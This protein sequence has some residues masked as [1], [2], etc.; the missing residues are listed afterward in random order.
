M[1]RQK[2][3]SGNRFAEQSA[4]FGDPVPELPSFA[5][6]PEETKRAVERNAIQRGV[7]L[8]KIL[9]SLNMDEAIATIRKIA[10]EYDKEEIR[11]AA[12]AL[13][14]DVV[15][16]T[17]LDQ[18]DPPIP[19]PW[20]FCTPTYLVENPRLVMYYRNVAMLSRKVMNGIGLGT[21][22][23]ELNLV[24]PPAS[25]AAE[26]AHYFNKIIGEL[27]KTGGVTPQR[28][29]EMAFANLGDSLGGV[30]RNEVGRLAST[31]V[32]R[33]L[34]IHLHQKWHLASLTYRLKGRVMP[35]D[36]EDEDRVDS[37]ADQVLTVSP[38]MDLESALA[39]L[40]SQR[41]KYREV[42]LRNGNRLLLD[43]QL[44][45]HGPEG[46]AFRIGPDLHAQSPVV[47]MLWAGEIKGGADPAGSEEHW[48]TAT[49]ALSRI[50]EASEKTGRSKPAL[51][52]L[53]TIIVERVAREAQAWIDQGKLTSVYN[54]TKIAENPLEQQLFLDE[55]TVFLGCD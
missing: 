49:Q 4:F 23:Y 37:G 8:V 55:M 10:A 3:R 51:S 26:L 43:R 19:Y 34:A 46:K 2:R 54:L 16:L 11:E 35:D 45:W 17:I 20:Y 13:G 24:A 12:E 22:G 9:V 44:E 28:H 5:S 25:V 15:A 7:L 33:L 41:V 21:E 47:D 42:T 14:I 29:I 53:A 18:A 31:Q 40:E 36:E 27:I 32:I 30:S 38:E 39:R 48:K 52:F 6:T 1:V 50:L